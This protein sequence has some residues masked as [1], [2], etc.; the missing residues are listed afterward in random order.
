GQGQSERG[1]R[2]V[3]KIIRAIAVRRAI[4]I[5]RA[6]SLHRVDVAGLGVLAPAKHQV[7]K[8]VC[9]S[10]FPRFFVFR[11]HVIPGIHRDNRRF[12]IF[13][14]DHRQTV[15]EHKLLIGNVYFLRA[16]RNCRKYETD[17]K[18]P[19]EF[20]SRP[21]HT[22]L[23][24]GIQKKRRTTT[25]ELDVGV[26]FRLQQFPLAEEL[27]AK[28]HGPK[29]YTAAPRVLQSSFT[30]RFQ[31]QIKLSS[32]VELLTLASSWEQGSTAAFRK[33]PARTPPAVRTMFT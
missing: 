12:V 15:I 27:P 6:D 18:H 19:P 13:M 8:Q 4:Q 33:W 30:E 32:L 3:L 9:E 29:V 23:N 28:T 1:G 5:R 22:L 20:H 25:C 24:F 31:C 21:P 2:H 17:S 26:K 7:L 10:R 11:S 14:H 16:Y